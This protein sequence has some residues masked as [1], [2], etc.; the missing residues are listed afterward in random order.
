MRFASILAVT[1]LCA[2]MVHA[3]P[4]TYYFSGEITSINGTPPAGVAVG[5]RFVG[6]YTFDSSIYANSH[7]AMSGWY[8]F[9]EPGAMRLSVG[10]L[11]LISG[12]QSR[13]EVHNDSYGDRLAIWASDFVSNGVDVGG[14]VIGLVD[15]SGSVFDDAANPLVVAPIDRFTSAGLNLEGRPV[16]IRR[17]RGS[18]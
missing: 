17:A 9:S 13:I 18:A 16:W 4:F 3:G 2:S 15:D 12:I 7:P 10:D 5:D 8:Y 14:I 11:D 6:S 1:L